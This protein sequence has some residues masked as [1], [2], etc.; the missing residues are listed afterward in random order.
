MTRIHQ[1]RIGVMGWAVNGHCKHYANRKHV[2][3][4]YVFVRERINDGTIQLEKLRTEQRPAFL[5]TKAV[6][7]R[8]LQ[9]A[10]IEAEVFT[11]PV[12][13]KYGERRYARMS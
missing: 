3:L 2:T 8:V 13:L 7:T 6:Q 11:K 12:Y 5:L 1:D 9:K 4:R 10:V